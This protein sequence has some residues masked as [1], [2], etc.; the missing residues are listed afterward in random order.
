MLMKCNEKQVSVCVSGFAGALALALALALVVVLVV[1]LGVEVQVAVPKAVLVLEADLL[2]DVA[3][4]CMEATPLAAVV[5][6]QW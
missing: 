6:R 2:P 3:L 5:G 1:A 4:D